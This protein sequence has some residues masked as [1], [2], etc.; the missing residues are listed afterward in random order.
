[1]KPAMSAQPPDDSFD[2]L[3]DGRIDVDQLLVRV[4]E[5]RVTRRRSG[6]TR[7]KTAPPPTNGS[8]YLVK[9]SRGDRASPAAREGVL[10]A[11]PLED[12]PRG[13]HSAPTWPSRRR[14]ASSSRARAS[15]AKGLQVWRS[16]NSSAESFVRVSTT[17]SSRSYD[18][19]LSS[20]SAARLGQPAGHEVSQRLGVGHLPVMLLGCRD[21]D[22]PGPSPR[23]TSG[24]DRPSGPR[25]H[26]TARS[27]PIPPRLLCG[28]NSG[29]M[30]TTSTS[31]GAACEHPA[32][33]SHLDR[34]DVHQR[35]RAGSQVRHR[36]RE[37]QG[38]LGDG[39]GKHDGLAGRPPPACPREAERGGLLAL[40]AQI[41][42]DQVEARAKVL[43]G[44][45]AEPAESDQ[46]EIEQRKASRSCARIRI[47][48]HEC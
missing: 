20:W 47:S 26:S 36:L 41:P 42:D 5:D 45:L 34:A 10:A 2:I 37:R 19:V 18:G 31:G 8:M 44:E 40:V 33:R 39:H 11:G 25:R 46:P 24:S 35:Q 48:Y 12:G 16:A 22:R 28:P 14:S 4:G 17:L 9:R 38:H 3:L 1:M 29:C 6:V 32:H 7:K 30:P 21:D 15:A 27:P 43:G 23:G 13:N